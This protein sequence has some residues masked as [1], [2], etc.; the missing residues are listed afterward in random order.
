MVLTNQSWTDKE[1]FSI[2]DFTVTAQD[3]VISS[4]VIVI[5]IVIGSLIC[6]YISWRKRHAIAD[7][8]RRASTFIVRQSQILRNTIKS[9]MGQPTEAADATPVDPN[10][11][12][13]SR[14]EK[15]FLKDMFKYQSAHDVFDEGDTVNQNSNLS[16]FE[17]GNR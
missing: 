7:G 4:T 8:A 17:T 14:N 15:E 10:K 6:L 13:R 16:N 12:G 3:A 11:I 9:K 5:L 2:G 1:L